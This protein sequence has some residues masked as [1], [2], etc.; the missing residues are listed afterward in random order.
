MTTQV[1][2]DAFLPPEMAERMENVGVKKASLDVW[3]MF[4]LAVLAGCFIGLGAYRADR[5]YRPAI[6]HG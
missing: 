6:W 5:E 4:A 3:S 2:I 1:T